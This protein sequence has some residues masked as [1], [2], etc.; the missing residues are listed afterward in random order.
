MNGPRSQASVPDWVAAFRNAR[1]R[2]PRVLHLGNIANNAYLNARILREAGFECDVACHDYYH[3]MGC[4]EW[5]DA[6]VPPGTGDHFRPWW[7]RSELGSFRRPRWFAQGPRELVIAYL[8][9]LRRG[10]RIRAALGWRTLAAFRFLRARG[11]AFVRRIGLHRIPGAPSAWRGLRRA[12]GG[13]RRRLA[14]VPGL[15][16][17][18]RAIGALP[19]LRR[20]N[21]APQP[22]PGPD[23]RRHVAELY[24]KRFERFGEGEIEAVVE[25]AL[26][27][28]PLFREYDAV[29]G[30]ATDGILPLAAGKRPYLAY[31]H[32]TIRHLPFQDTPAGRECALCYAEADEVL[33]TNC[34]NRA[35]AE[36]LGLRRYRFV[37]HPVNER[38]LAE[39]CRRGE[40]LGRR[41]RAELGCRFL[42][43]HPARQH[44][45]PDR[46]PDWEKGNDRLI[47]GFAAF[48][49]EIEGDAVAVFVEWGQRLEQSRA[50][51]RELGIEERVRW[52]PPL[53]HRRMVPYMAAADAVADQFHL[54]AFG[55][56]TPKALACARPVLLHLDEERHRWCFPELP[57]VLNVREP[58]AVRDA[59]LRLYRSPEEAAALGR[60]GRA[61][62]R[63]YH[64]AARV[65]DRLGRAIAEAVDR[66]GGEAAPG[67]R[68]DLR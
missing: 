46:H 62:Y 57:P 31:E 61:W 32:G 8:G 45:G 67:A 28:R 29:I 19:G 43:F 54:G 18:R 14:G 9:D 52:I 60:A 13:L 47:R 15:R 49:R 68:A 48:L 56:I 22:T 10:R 36:R 59:L 4:P 30:Y 7:S 66:A 38:D 6:D 51:L 40:D 50:L 37:P 2:P 5:E 1:G 12:G 55:S 63:K 26:A 42:V 11:Y 33:I 44:W 58:E 35:S 64:S 21:P 41:L 17:L 24:R 53:P 3:L 34:D 20:M 39:L 23:L 65:A 16:R 27:W 25:R